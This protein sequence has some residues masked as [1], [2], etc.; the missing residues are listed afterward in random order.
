MK[1]QHPIAILQYTSKNFWL[2]IIPIIRGLITPNFDFYNWLEGAY[3]DLAV[4]IFILGSAFFRWWFIKYEFNEDKF[5]YSGGLIFKQKFELPYSIISAISTKRIFWLRPTKAV[6]I[7]IDSETQSPMNRPSDTDV[8]IITDVKMLDV[9]F[10]KVPQKSNAITLKYEASKTN[11]LIFSFVFSSTLSGIVFIGTFFI[12]GSKVV[13]EQ[14]ESRFLT[15]VTG[16]TTI[17]EK[18]IAGV[19][20]I[21][22]GV[23]LILLGGWIISFLSNLLRHMNFC[24]QREGKCITIQNGFFSKWHYFINAEKINYTDVRQNLLMK[25]FRVMSVHVSCSGY[26]KAKNE[27]PVFVPVTT[28]SRVIGSMQMLLPN[29][30]LQKVRFKSKPKYLFRFIGLPLIMIISILIAGYLTAYF[31]PSWYE[32]IVFAVIMLEIPAC[33]MLI[34]KVVAHYTN[35]IEYTADSLTLDYCRFY[36][37]HKVIIPLSRITMVKI[38]QNIFQRKNK[39]CDIIIFTKAEFTKSHRVKGLTIDDANEILKGLKIYK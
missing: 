25:L 6:S 33:Y 1:R 10:S 19:T 15:A 24:I 37:F 39:S 3:I 13:G 26:G 31:L 36:Q 7:H 11:L 29:F 27:I 35:G 14:L 34:V 4:V 23:S 28:R 9:I 5:S 38:S 20:P 2:L 17:A 16:I 30:K 21:A 32:V 18:V 22:V 8:F 12:E